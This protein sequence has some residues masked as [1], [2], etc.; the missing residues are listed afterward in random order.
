M[1]GNLKKQRFFKSDRILFTILIIFFS[2][3]LTLLHTRLYPTVFA[4]EWIYSSSSRLL[5]IPE[6]ITPS[7]LFLLLFK[8]TN[9]CG[10]DFLICARM[11]N[12]FVFALSMPF[13]YLISRKITS[14]SLAIFIAIISLLGPINSYTAYF[15]PE[16]LYFFAFWL[17][18]WFVL[19]NFQKSAIVFG[20]GSGLILGLMSLIK[21][22][23]IFLIPGWIIFLILLIFFHSAMMNLKKAILSVCYLLLIFLSVRWLIGFMIAGQSGLNLVGQKY[24]VNMQS[25]FHIDRFFHI[26]SMIKIP[27][28]GHLIALI[29]FFSVPFA[30]IVN[31][32]RKNDISNQIQNNLKSIQLFALSVTAILLFVTI[33]STAQM[34]G[35][36]PYD[37]VNRIH[38]RYYNF[39]FPLFYIIAS[40]DIFSPTRQTYPLRI[41]I[42][43]SLICLSFFYALTLMKKDFV[44]SFIDCPELFG[45]IYHTIIFKFLSVMSLACFMTWLIRKKWGAILYVLFFFPIALLISSY[46]VNLELQ[47]ERL[48]TTDVY[49]RAGQFTYRFLGKDTSKLAILGSERGGLFKTLFYID[50]PKASIIELPPNVPFE[51]AKIPVEKIWVLVIGDYPFLRKP[52]FQISMGDFSLIKLKNE[53]K[54]PG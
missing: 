9:Y 12:S 35:W 42:F 54:F 19:N 16:A 24:S 27:L 53:K 44:I 32:V 52:Y 38:M 33:F 13:I 7:Y 49:D 15:M 50:N 6:S 14:R 10:T 28:M 18:A 39:I 37:V 30:S 36:G 5:P 41:W 43:I 22:H 23:A 25:L 3:F 40:A 31:L 26:L 21:M 2:A 46:F 11:I 48:L 8:S 29:L 51:F 4:D 1:I 45:F 17:F 47:Q 20:A 34:V